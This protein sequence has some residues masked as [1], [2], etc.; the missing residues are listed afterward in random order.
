[1]GIKITHLPGNQEK[2]IAQDLANYLKQKYNIYFEIKLCG[3][4]GSYDKI[5]ER[6]A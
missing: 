4:V 3:L 6:I 1:M 2:E 5:R